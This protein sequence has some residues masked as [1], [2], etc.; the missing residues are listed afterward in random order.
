MTSG[1]TWFNALPPADA[2]RQL[3]ACCAS[4]EWAAQVAARRPYKDEAALNAAADAAFDGLDLDEPLAAHPRIGDRPEG[5]GRAAAWSRGEQAGVGEDARSALRE[6]NLAYEKRFGR[7]FLICA[8]GL[9][10]RE[11]LENLERRLGHDDATEH[12]TVRGELLKI[13]HLRLAKLLEHP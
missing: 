6:G 2:E 8:T 1:L 13:T 12:R 9:S 3:R 7:V 5:S 11:M 10:A 4:A